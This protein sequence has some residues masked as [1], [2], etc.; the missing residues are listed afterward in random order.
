MIYR[1]AQCRF[2]ITR[3][4][5]RKLNLKLTL[6]YLNVVLL[7]SVFFQNNIQKVNNTHTTKITILHRTQDNYI[8]D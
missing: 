8:A 2:F 4:Y 5:F 7:L 6:A 3:D 1:A